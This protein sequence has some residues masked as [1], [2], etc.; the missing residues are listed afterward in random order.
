MLSPV[1]IDNLITAIEDNDY[2]AYITPESRYH[3]L[4]EGTIESSRLERLATQ[5]QEL[6]SQD[7]FIR[8]NSASLGQALVKQAWSRVK[9]LQQ[10]LDHRD[11]NLDAVMKG[12]KL[13][14]STYPE[15]SA[16]QVAKLEVGVL[17]L[18]VQRF[19]R[20]AGHTELSL[21][22]N[23]ARLI[24]S[25]LLAFEIL[26]RSKTN[27]SLSEEVK[28]RFYWAWYLL[29]ALVPTPKHLK[30]AAE[31]CAY[32]IRAD[33]FAAAMQRLPQALDTLLEF[34][35]GPM[36]E[37][38]LRLLSPEDRS[39]GGGELSTLP[40]RGSGVDI[41]RATP[42]SE[43]QNVATNLPFP[44]ATMQYFQDVQGFLEKAR[45][46]KEALLQEANRAVSLAF[47]QRFGAGVLPEKRALIPVSVLQAHTRKAAQQLD[48]L[49]REFGEVP[50]KNAVWH[51]VTDLGA[52]FS[53]AAG[54]NCGELEVLRL[55]WGWLTNAHE[56]A[57]QGQV[58]EEVQGGRDVLA[59]A[60]ELSLEVGMWVLA[61]PQHAELVSR[62]VDPDAVQEVPEVSLRLVL[63]YLVWYH[64]PLS[65]ECFL[66]GLGLAER[67]ALK[68]QMQECGH[69]W[70]VRLTELQDSKGKFAAL[71]NDVYCDREARNQIVSL[72]NHTLIQW[73][74]EWIL[75]KNREMLEG[76]WN[77]LV[78]KER[79]FLEDL[80]CQYVIVQAQESGDRPLPEEFS[81]LDGS[82]EIRR[83]LSNPSKIQALFDVGHPEVAFRILKFAFQA[84]DSTITSDC[85]A[86]FFQAYKSAG[87]NT[88]KILKNI[89]VQQNDALFNDFIQYARKAALRN[90]LMKQMMATLNLEFH[91]V[92]D[93]LVVK[94]EQ[95]HRHVNLVEYTVL[96]PIFERV[97]QEQ[98]ERL[99]LIQ[100][101]QYPATLCS[102]LFH[103]RLET[104]AVPRFIEELKENIKVLS[105]T[106]RLEIRLYLFGSKLLPYASYRN[107]L[108]LD[109]L[110]R[111]RTYDNLLAVARNHV[112]LAGYLVDEFLTEGEL[113]ECSALLNS[114]KKQ[115]D[116]ALVYQILFY[117][118]KASDLM[119]IEL[120]KESA[121]IHNLWQEAGTVFQQALQHY[122]RQ[123]DY[124]A[125]VKLGKSGQNGAE[126][127]ILKWLVLEVFAQ[128]EDQQA[129]WRFPCCRAVILQ[130]DN[131]H[132]FVTNQH[133]YTIEDLKTE[134]LPPFLEG[135][136]D[137]QFS[138]IARLL[139]LS[140]VEDKIAQAFAALVRIDQLVEFFFYH[141]DTTMRE[142]IFRRIITQSPYDEVDKQLA[143]LREL[144]I[145]AS[146][147]LLMDCRTR[148]ALQM[149]A[150]NSQTRSLPVLHLLLFQVRFEYELKKHRIDVNSKVQFHFWHGRSDGLT[151]YHLDSIQRYQAEYVK[152]VDENRDDEFVI[153]FRKL[154][155]DLL[156]IER[157][158]A[159]TSDVP[160][161][162]P[163]EQ[164][165]A[166]LAA[167]V[168]S[169]IRS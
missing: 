108:R 152:T 45:V 100:N 146:P 74:F 28:E 167:N 169:S 160:Y 47:Y 20:I 63:N 139:E 26:L 44:S 79:E 30:E 62:L 22:L 71:L 132:Y 97:F 122:L 69:A 135:G 133:H 10:S 142:E 80:M 130:H 98:A 119:F 3:L 6:A 19:Q 144:P 126:Q 143:L 9:P 162:T 145:C 151:L 43:S 77:H 78:G 114:Y 96:T 113:K 94:V 25:Q 156:T 65:I 40:Q 111:E 23:I 5:L 88:Q 90:P 48:S 138:N 157:F 16:L 103:L 61:Q 32:S 154:H 166:K 49:W 51:N 134:L 14:Y 163:E 52:L 86:A 141:K 27:P 60:G 91:A 53:R 95:E 124:A 120:T 129:L 24:A 127:L 164:L 140:I 87:L 165:N 35:G 123:N 115:G 93:E 84:E 46:E 57:L 159:Q 12:L 18:F 112:Q 64:E 109:L 38:S 92:H 72:S 13:L 31:R 55:Y 155:R 102:A 158:N 66:P 54:G 147:M 131:F 67:K 136:L 83:V 89:F 15:V 125:M 73:I 150:E 99:L 1:T 149:M 128:D 137:I 70:L 110:P 56:M 4:G 58:L 33:E 41:Y 153:R 36:R 105:H 148:E 39:E 37:Y 106:A 121:L 168:L 82:W 75:P 81:L 116:L 117:S 8:I 7:I 2:P 161:P 101:S 29:A 118:T 21:E 50:K 76:I 11:W 104:S 59:W 68:R 85:L 42:V 107:L 17:D 34:R